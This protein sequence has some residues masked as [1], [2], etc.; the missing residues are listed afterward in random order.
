MTLKDIIS[1]VLIYKPKYKGKKFKLMLNIGKEKYFNSKT[2][3]VWEIREFMYSLAKC[4]NFL[5]KLEMVEYKTKKPLNMTIFQDF[6]IVRKKIKRYS[7]WLKGTNARAKYNDTII[8][9]FQSLR[10]ALAFK[11]V[12]LEDSTDVEIR[13]IKYLSKPT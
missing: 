8:P 10:A 9:E 7:I 2:I 13:V 1:D 5:E 6:K 3:P 11:T 12:I 4:S